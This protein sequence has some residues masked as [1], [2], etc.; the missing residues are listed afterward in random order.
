[1]TSVAVEDHGID[2]QQRIYSVRCPDGY[3]VG[4]THDFVAKQVCYAPLNGKEACIPGDSLD[5]A[6]ALAC[7]QSRPDRKSVR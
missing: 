5:A 4:L 1:M 6:A 7:R 2:G 3:R